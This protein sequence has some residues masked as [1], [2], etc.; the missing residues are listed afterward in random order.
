MKKSKYSDE[1]AAASMICSGVLIINSRDD[2]NTAEFKTSAFSSSDLENGRGEAEKSEG[3]DDYAEYGQNVDDSI[4][5]TRT[6]TYY[7]TVEA[8][9]LGESPDF[10]RSLV[11]A[12][13]VD[14]DTLY[15]VG[16]LERECSKGSPVRY[17]K[18]TYS[19][20]VGEN[21]SYSM[22]EANVGNIRYTAMDFAMYVNNLLISDDSIG[23]GLYIQIE[24]GIAKFVSLSS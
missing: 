15:V 20:K 23:L 1:I 18:G 11:T 10:G 14:N 12:F 9:G 19:F 4:L 7:S 5:L 17:S 22:G 24:N 2:H 13:Y 3:N 8:R 16:S 6:G 21:T